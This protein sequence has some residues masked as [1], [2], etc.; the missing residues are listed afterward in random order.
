MTQQVESSGR[1]TAV[2]GGVALA[3]SGMLGIGVLLGPAPAAA[4]A[5]PWSLLG[6]PIALVT[7]ICVAS[8]TA[9]QSNSYGGPGPAYAC[10]RERMGLLAARVAASA[11]LAGQVAAMAAVARVLGDLFLP[12]AAPQVAA[13]AILLV[14]L[15]ATTGLRIRGGA[16][17]LWTALSLLVVGLVVATC[18]AIAPVGGQPAGQVADSAVG[19]FGAA[20]VL[21]VAFLGIERLTAPDGRRL[22]PRVVKRAAVISL[23]VVTAVLALMM[24]ALA[25]QLGWARLALS[26]APLRDVL[27]A[28]AAADMRP[29]V[30]AGAAVALLPVLLG[31]LESWRS[32]AVALNRDG[33]LPRALGRTGSAGTPYL[34]DLLGGVAAVLVAQWVSPVAAMSFA[35]C[36]LL[37]HYALASAG[38]RLLLADGP[39]W[40]TRLACLG[41]GLSVVVAM[42]MPIGAMLSTAV[43]VVLG[44]LVAGG[45]SR[46]WK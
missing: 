5:G 46:R 8:A 11:F 18:F 13:V 33:E 10:V 39:A 22:P 14:V 43:V 4:A 16:A 31:A 24:L 42:S 20:G 9:H 6:L 36:A 32:T 3:L 41:M 7:A 26:P 21:F 1:S 2:G 40:A 38:A 23:S 15:S 19:P 27:T 37:L 17:W 29:L 45:V 12:S 44:P 35:A 25:H 34:L 30:S 28:A